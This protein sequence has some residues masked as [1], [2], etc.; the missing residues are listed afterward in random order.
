MNFFYRWHEEGR[1]AS[2]SIACLL[3]GHECD[4]QCTRVKTHGRVQRICLCRELQHDGVALIGMLETWH[5][6]GSR[7]CRNN[8]Q[9]CC[10][11]KGYGRKR[12]RRKSSVVRIPVI[13]DPIIFKR[14]CNVPYYTVVVVPPG[15]FHRRTQVRNKCPSARQSTVS[16]KMQRFTPSTAHLLRPHV[17]QGVLFSLGSVNNTPSPSR[18]R[19]LAHAKSTTLVARY[20]S[21]L[22]LHRERGAQGADSDEMRV[23]GNLLR[24]A[25]HTG[26]THNKRRQPSAQA[27]LSDATARATTHTH[28]SR[29]RNSNVAQRHL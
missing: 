16:L 18:L 3:D 23:R 6:I 19:G 24:L 8:F 11:D 7:N 27:H 5:R 10:I 15:G 13:H 12:E 25:R 22:G 28:K 17:S 9:K 26:Y 2:Q 21:S 14:V 29:K 20:R 4:G 1:Q